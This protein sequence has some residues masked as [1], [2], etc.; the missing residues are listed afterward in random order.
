MSLVLC[1]VILLLYILITFYTN[2]YIPLL[3][4]TISRLLVAIANVLHKY[5]TDS[6]AVQDSCTALLTCKASL[7]PQATDTIKLLHS[8]AL[9]AFP[10]L[11]ITEN[12][13]LIDSAL[14][15]VIILWS[16]YPQQLPP[17]CDVSQLSIIVNAAL[18]V[19]THGHRSGAIQVGRDLVGF[20]M[21]LLSNQQ[22][23]EL[24]ENGVGQ[25]LRSLLAY[26]DEMPVESLQQIVVGV[27]MLAELKFE[28]QSFLDSNLHVSLLF[29]A[30]KYS[31][32]HTLQQL[33]WKLFSMLVRQDRSFA[34][35]L[36]SCDIL[37]AI[38]A[39]MQ[40]EGYQ[41]LPL[42]RFLTMC[43]HQVP[44]PFML[45]CLENKELLGQLLIVA[46][47]DSTFGLESVTNTCDF[48]SFV[49]S[50][51][52]PS[53]VS[54][55]VDLGVVLQLEDCA[56]KWPEACMLPACLAIEGLSM[57]YPLEKQSDEYKKKREEFFALNHHL[58]I[59]DMLCNEVVYV[60]GT[61]VELIYITFQKLLRVCTA[62]ALQR[63][64]SKEFI[65]FFVIAFVRDTSA[66]PN[67][68]SRI[69]FTAHY[70][71]FQ[72]KHKDGFENLKEAGF[73]DAVV[74]VINNSSSYELTVTAMGLIASLMV[75]YLD[76]F[77]N[78]KM[79]LNTSLPEL[80]VTKCTEYGH[81]PKSQFGDDF[82]RVLL[83]LTAD[84]EMSLELYKRGY[85]SQLIELMDG[86]YISIVR[87]SIIHAVGNIAL[88]GQHIK[89]ELY[90]KEFY[91]TMLRILQDE[92]E[93]SDAFLLSACCRV[94][95]ILASGDWAKRKFVERGCPEILLRLLKTRRD[96]PEVSWRPL[97]LLSSI[98]FMAVSNRRYVLTSEVVETISRILREWKNGKVI[99]YAVLIFLACGELDEGTVQ[100]R[101]LA[102]ESDLMKAMENEEYK[103]QAPDLVRWGSHVLEKQY[104]YTL[105]AS[106][107]VTNSESFPSPSP[108]TSRLDWPP[109]PPHF[110]SDT[111]IET[112]RQNN[113]CYRL[114]PID[115]S[116]LEPQYPIAP[117]ISESAKQKL[118][119]LGHDPDQ[120]LFRVGRVYGST[121]GFCSN[122]D[123]DGT[124]E[125]LVIRPHS[126]TPH[127]YQQ[128]I[129]NGWYRRGGVKMFRLRCNHNVFCCDWETRVNV[130]K[131]NK[132]AHKSYGRV[133]RRMP[134]ERLTVETKPTNFDREAF[135][136]Y[137][138]YHVKKHDKP[139]KS[140]FSYC[141][142]IVNSPLQQQTIDGI[143]YGTF[144][145]LYRFD[146]K[147]VAI[148]II[149]VVPKGIVS[150]YMWYDVSK[151]VSKYSF[152]VYS[153]LKE[154]ELVS[155]YNKLNPNM[156][157]YYL[158][159]WNASNR[160]LSYKANYSPED[161]F[162]PS[163]VQ[164][165]VAELEGVRQ[166][167]QLCVQRKKKVETEKE[168]GRKE[169]VVNGSNMNETDSPSVSK[170]SPSMTLC[171][172][173]GKES[174]ST[175][176]PREDGKEKD[177]CDKDSSS[178]S[179]YVCESYPQDLARY[180]ARTG[181]A[182]VDL[183][184][185]VVCL[186]YTEYTTFSEALECY[187]VPESQRSM[188][189]KRYSEL[190]VALSPELVAQLVIDLK[191]CMHHH[192][193]ESTTFAALQDVPM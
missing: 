187:Q 116:F 82:S 157:N 163:I 21:R 11:K 156:H 16:R 160:K 150:I 2:I 97:G 31:T 173:H 193:Q 8:R 105:Q 124:S 108:F 149:D 91:E 103:T 67:Q 165:W 25:K 50:K 27:G 122:C 125:E 133:L 111:D 49:C 169:V 170:A 29:A 106:P 35:H 167:Q 51:L 182:E 136:L 166:C 15:V 128:L 90:D 23:R 40:V 130:L 158:Q 114:L 80:L 70:F 118:R 92:L 41:L 57:P 32:N 162:C 140:E 94:L 184:H 96:N 52:P 119:H 73:H 186:N 142:H 132:K 188:M 145:Q 1:P 151:E 83:N 54:L 146:G 72:M 76:H 101:E 100:L 93:R 62:D 17:T 75:K 48:L 117:E 19:E 147:L 143:D 45:R 144:H 110:T 24:E 138:D 69:A 88:G 37:S 137:N 53:H 95:H 189:E 135:D 34:G 55:V 20:L 192:Q 63:M 56:R 10:Q 81:K 153:A 12:M 66:F 129:D 180:T 104:L 99:S 7:P 148:G 5:S 26:Y 68:A 185:V 139:W 33:V 174:S 43:C 177:K 171:N 152:G 4:S 131:F 77:K 6:K 30:Q 115:E 98:G 39:I 120:P 178:I 172:S 64:C 79:F 175:D 181:N 46:H 44:A 176:V 22:L 78:V 159:G 9:A 126:L 38:V 112:Q 161:F 59:K 191:V 107:G 13:E 58:F 190:I 61:L 121:H 89:Q 168:G 87:R 183:S 14:N 42:I 84:K 36:L 155:E 123:K 127:Q 3:F 86:N 47:P 85:M 102:I 113:N 71:V 179:A 60:N 65:E 18:D 141:E 28:A 154:I 109:K 134:A 74:G 164:D